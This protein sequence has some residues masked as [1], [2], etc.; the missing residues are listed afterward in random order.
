MSKTS[1]GKD[2]ASSDLNPTVKIQRLCLTFSEIYL[3]NQEKPKRGLKRWFR[4]NNYLIKREK[5]RGR[6][7]EYKGDGP[8][9][10]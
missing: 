1:F 2:N 3:I 10:F 4:G 5:K 7:A 9:L 6:I 8:F